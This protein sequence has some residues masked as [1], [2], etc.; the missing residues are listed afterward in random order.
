MEQDSLLQPADHHSPL[1]PIDSLAEKDNRCLCHQSR[2][3]KER[4]D[5]RAVLVGTHPNRKNN[6]GKDGPHR[7]RK[8]HE[9]DQSIARSQTHAAYIRVICLIIITI[10]S[11]KTS[12]E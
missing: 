9:G 7:I 12:A 4:P 6:Q 8:D 10:S 11:L 3:C 1:H 5:N 2:L